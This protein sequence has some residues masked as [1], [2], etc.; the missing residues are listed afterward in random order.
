MARALTAAPMT[1]LPLSLPPVTRALVGL[2]QIVLVW[3]TRRTSRQALKQ[4]DTH[5]LRDIGLDTTTAGVEAAK[6]FWKA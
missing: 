6:P 1:T 3:E 4:L 5:M 2:A